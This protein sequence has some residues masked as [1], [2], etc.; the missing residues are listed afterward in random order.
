MSIEDIWDGFGNQPI[1]GFPIYRWVPAANLQFRH[2]PDTFDDTRGFNWGPLWGGL[3][4]HILISECIQS[5]TSN[6]K[7]DIVIRT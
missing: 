2:F 6:P 3:K 1:D 7:L 5:P 4:I